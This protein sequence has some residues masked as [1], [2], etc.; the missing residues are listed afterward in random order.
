MSFSWTNNID[1]SGTATLATE[2]AQLVAWQNKIAA[3]NVTTGPA[4]STSALTA[5][6]NPADSGGQR[7]GHA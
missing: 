3:N 6:S 2:A 4:T 1:Y 7:P 5:P